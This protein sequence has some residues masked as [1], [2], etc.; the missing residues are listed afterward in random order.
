MEILVHLNKET[1]LASSAEHR[2][3]SSQAGEV[4][5]ESAEQTID[6]LYLASMANRV[7]CATLS[8]TK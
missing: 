8:Y 4:V 7:G 6:V 2:Y 5:C 1:Q 3:L